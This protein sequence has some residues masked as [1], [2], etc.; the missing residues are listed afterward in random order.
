M[1]GFDKIISKETEQEEDDTLASESSSS[2]ENLPPG[3]FSQ[4]K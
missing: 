4:T 3:L 2:Y 1:E